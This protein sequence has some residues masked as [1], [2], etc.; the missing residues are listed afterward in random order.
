M[1]ILIAC[2][3]PI[4]CILFAFAVEA[5]ISIGVIAIII[6]LLYIIVKKIEAAK[7]AKKEKDKLFNQYYG[8]SETDNE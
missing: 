2:L 3:L 4:A 1:N 5:Y 6:V 7:I 8:G